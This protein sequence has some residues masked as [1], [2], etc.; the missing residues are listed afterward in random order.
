MGAGGSGRYIFSIISQVQTNVWMNV[1]SCIY[2]K[3][4]ITEKINT[5]MLFP[6]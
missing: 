5:K 4:K 2:T 3:K 1:K 6:L